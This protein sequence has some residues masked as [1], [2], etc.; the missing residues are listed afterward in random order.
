ML[1]CNDA[2][3]MVS[4]N[5]AIGSYLAEKVEEST[6]IPGDAESWEDASGL[7]F[8]AAPRVQSRVTSPSSEVRCIATFPL[9]QPIAQ[10]ISRRKVQ[11]CS[12]FLPG[13]NKGPKRSTLELGDLAVLGSKHS[14]EG[15]DCEQVA[16][17]GRAHEVRGESWIS[18]NVCTDYVE[19]PLLSQP[20]QSAGTHGTQFYSQL[21]RAKLVPSSWVPEGSVPET[22][23]MDPL[24]ARMI[25]CAR[26]TWVH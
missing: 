13:D 24:L 10:L 3:L 12:V 18:P 21:S 20:E 6:L 8:D 4:R 1:S 19:I 9:P 22:F 26:M 23:S 16:V 15:S 17:S 11:P 5:M 7:E 25:L 14:P 2:T